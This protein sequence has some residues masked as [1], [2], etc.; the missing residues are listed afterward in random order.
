MDE[1]GLRV[2]EANTTFFSKIT[3]SITKLLIPTKVG[4]NNMLITMKRNNVIKAYDA[5][6]NLGEIQDAKSCHYQ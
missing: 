2:L 1:K 5:Y 3:T 6:N 4:I